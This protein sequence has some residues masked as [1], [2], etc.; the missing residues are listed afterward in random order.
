MAYV[1]PLN[2]YVDESDPDTVYMTAEVSVLD[3]EILSVEARTNSKPSRRFTTDKSSVPMPVRKYIYE[4]AI[5]QAQKTIRDTE[6]S[7]DM[8]QRNMGKD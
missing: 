2:D 7:M 3:G 6:R 4:Q 1:I 5:S 8:M